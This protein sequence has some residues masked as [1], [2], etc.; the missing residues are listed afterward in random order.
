MPK[1]YVI[2]IA[3]VAGS[4]KSTLGR[5]LAVHL[6]APLL[7]L[8]TLT[9]PLLDALHDSPPGEHWLSSSRGETIRA[10][11]YRA[12]RSVARDVIGTAGCAVLV[13]PFT[14][15]LTGGEDWRA[16]GVDMA[17]ADVVV[18]RIVGDPELLAQRRTYRG[19]PR[20][21][22]RGT[23]ITPPVGVPT[24]T[25]DADLSTAQQLARLLPRLGCRR[26]IDEKSPVFA[27]SFDAVLFDLDGTLVDST[28]SVIRSWRRF[29]EEYGISMQAL[30][31]NHGQPAAALIDRVVAAERRPDALQRITALEVH[32]AIDLRP[33]LGAESFYASVPADRRAIVTSG[34]VSIAT[35]RLA[36]ANLREPDVF[37]TV[38]DVTK[39]KPDPEPYL[40]AAARIGVSPERCL[41]VEDAAAGVASAKAA[42]CRVVG[43]LGTV[44]AELLAAA[45]II[46]DGLDVMEIA[47][48]DGAL[49]LRS[50][51]RLV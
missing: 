2:A 39:G 11:R 4:G 50:R 31:E 30:H 43:V 18:V 33:V 51:H 34:S 36:A 47:V 42:G 26:A 37:V 38:E 12:L 8:D 5:A 27:N 21:A 29:A 23:D 3:G 48:D 28:A 15:E 10:A 41:V 14:S 24:L 49:R 17:P 9:N 32:D 45:D 22:H 7:D 6:G 44:E 46:V 19:E 16:L 40:T 1:P 25:V 13:A 35:A 20:D